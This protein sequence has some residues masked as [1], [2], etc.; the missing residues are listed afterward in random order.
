MEIFNFSGCC[1]QK[2]KSS[3]TSIHSDPKV[4]NQHFLEPQI[5]FL[6]CYLEPIFVVQPDHGVDSNCLTQT[7]QFELEPPPDPRKK[8]RNLK[9]KLRDIESL[10]ARIF[11]GQLDYPEPEQ[12]VKLARKEAIETKILELEST[13]QDLSF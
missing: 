13:L 11:S 10:E 7:R 6:P 3:S 5:V 8:L 1:K 9:K 12:F 2:A 4:L